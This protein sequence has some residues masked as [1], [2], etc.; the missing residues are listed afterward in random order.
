MFFPASHHF[1]ALIFCGLAPALDCRA[2]EVA[3][4]I[5]AACRQLVVVAAESWSD[6][7]GELRRYARSD[8]DAPWKAVGKSATVLL[9]ERGL[10]WGLGLHRMDVDAP[11]VKREGDRCAPAGVFALTNGFGFRP[12]PLRLPYLLLQPDSE[13]VDDPASRY[14]NRIVRRAAVAHP[15]WK[16]SEP[17][18]EIADYELGVVIGHNRGNVPGAGSCIFLHR[19]D[20]PRTGTAGCTALRPADLEELVRWLDAARQPVLVQ[21]PRSELPAGF[22]L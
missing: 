22:P 13:A 5:P 15:D 1:L 9:G 20:R 14:Y 7:R 18:R 11:R 8:P 12:R 10:A 16:S 6:A 19:W 2:G 4:A 17:M 21:L 3:K